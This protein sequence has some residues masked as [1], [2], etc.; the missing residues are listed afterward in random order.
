[1]KKMD[2]VKSGTKLIVS[3]GVGAI[4]GNA[5]ACTTPIGQLGLA[6]GLSVK[7]GSFV[8]SSMVSDKAVEYVE[9]QIDEVRDIFVKK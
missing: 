8:L 4:V 1:M 3:T 2:I 6:M 7:V 5:I 9:K